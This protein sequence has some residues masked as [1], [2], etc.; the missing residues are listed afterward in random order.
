[1]CACFLVEVTVNYELDLPNDG[2]AC[3]ELHVVGMRRLRTTACIRGMVRIA[4]RDLLVTTDVEERKRGVS[5]GVLQRG[6]LLAGRCGGLGLRGSS[7]LG[8]S[9][10]VVWFHRLFL[11][12]SGLLLFNYY[13][14]SVE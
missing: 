8:S 13:N 6:H 9:W 11:S 14:S 5:L 7:L 4:A 1:M 12:G 2:L 10:L 3:A